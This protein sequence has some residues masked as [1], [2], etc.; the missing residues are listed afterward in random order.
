MREYIPFALIV[1]ICGAVVMVWT[2]YEP[3]RDSDYWL[4]FHLAIIAVLGI[5]L[6][7]AWSI[8][9]MPAPPCALFRGKEK[10]SAFDYEGE[11]YTQQVLRPCGAPSIGY[12]YFLS[13]RTRV[14][15]CRD[16]DPANR[17]MQEWLE[18]NNRHI[19]LATIKRFP[20]TSEAE[21]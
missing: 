11:E 19:N 18:R 4:A 9:W 3:A 8:W 13:C 21:G 12:S 20:H 5:V 14:Y 1:V 17:W 10:I 6:I 2:L 7:T 15:F 16:H